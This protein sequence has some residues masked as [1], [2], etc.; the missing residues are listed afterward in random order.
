[1]IYGHM[2]ED[3]F[4][5]GEIGT[6]RGLVPS[7]FLQEAPHDPYALSD[8]PNAAVM[9]SGGMYQQ[10]RRSPH[11]SGAS[12]PRRGNA[13]PPGGPP[14]LTDSRPTSASASAAGFGGM[15]SPRGSI[16]GNQQQKQQQAQQAQQRHNSGDGEQVRKEQ[17]PVG[18][19]RR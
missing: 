7:N 18:A 3:G 17:R 10:Q 2:D 13:G 19:R 6:R 5:L 14:S 9:Q 11:D 1:M 12:T 4:Y 16:T 15:E 8:S